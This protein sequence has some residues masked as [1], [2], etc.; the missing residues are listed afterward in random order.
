MLGI[1]LSQVETGR[2]RVHRVHRRAG[3]S[4]SKHRSEIPSLFVARDYLERI[5]ENAAGK[6]KIPN[7]L[8]S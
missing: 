6:T 7:L 4:L 1:T 3:V 2:G 5:L 8:R